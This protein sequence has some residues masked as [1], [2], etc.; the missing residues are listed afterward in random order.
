MVLAA[1]FVEM[2]EL[3]LGAFEKHLTKV[4]ATIYTEHILLKSERRNYAKI[5]NANDDVLPMLWIKQHGYLRWITSVSA[6]K[7]TGLSS[8]R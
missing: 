3:S 1:F 6:S 8:N 5:N 4:S 7:I 2:A